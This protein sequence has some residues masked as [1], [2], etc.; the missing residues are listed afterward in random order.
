MQPYTYK[1]IRDNI[2]QIADDDGVY[3]TFVRGSGL[4]VL[5]DTGYGKRDL[6]AF[7][8]KNVSTPYIVMNS[9]GHPDHTGGNDKQELYDEIVKE[10]HVVME[11][12][13]EWQVRKD[14]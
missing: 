5:I 4:A 11:K 2:W 13:A 7:V 1:K 10:F 9:H 8:E 12:R 3:C 14:K 6:R